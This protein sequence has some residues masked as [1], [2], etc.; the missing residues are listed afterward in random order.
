LVKT[1]PLI[2]EVM[3]LEQWEEAF[4]KS[5]KGMGIKYLLTPLKK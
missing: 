5:S 3:L 4:D 1:K 2:S